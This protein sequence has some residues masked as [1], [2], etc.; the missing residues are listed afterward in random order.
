MSRVVY[1]PNMSDHAYTLSAALRS[2]GI[3]SEAL[4]EPDEESLELG[5]KYSSGRECF[6]FVVTTGDILKKVRE[7]GF[8][9][10]EAA[11]FMPMASGPCRF[12]QYSRMHRIIL[13]RLGYGDVP[14]VSPTSQNA[15]EEIGG[16]G[17]AFRIKGWQALVATDILQKLLHQTRP[18]EVNPGETEQVYNQALSILVKAVETGRNLVDVMREIREDF[19]GIK[20][21]RRVIKPIIGVV[22]EIFMRSNRFSNN[23]VVKKLEELGA[24]VWL[25]PISEWIH[26]TCNR[27]KVES[28]AQRRYRDI[29]KAF[30]LEKLQRYYEGR[31]EK[32]FHGFLPNC[33]EPPIEDILERSSPYIHFS[34]GGEAILSVG[35]AIDYVEKGA[36]GI[37]NVMP[38]T[39]M[40]GM[41]VTAVSK[42]LR[43]DLNGLP[44]LNA[45]YDGHED[46]STQIRLE[47]FIYQARQY[48]QASLSGSFHKRT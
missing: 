37:V 11:F 10:G 47:A 25:A 23:Q 8:K 28:I 45:S 44:W 38:F 12:G 14:V 34:F 6:P 27:F 41:V 43:E 30:F 5:R 18:Y 36:C 20:V 26:Y 4:P 33:H 15:Y 1:I 40:P 13:D 32:T 29:L 48:R 46:T 39:C 42:R 9:P 31:L 2:C 35:K 19:E 7:P 22:G 3:A 24:E 21:D 16:A 17:M